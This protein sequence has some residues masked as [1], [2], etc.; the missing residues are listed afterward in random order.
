MTILGKSAQE[1]NPLIE[2]GADK[3]EELGKQAHDAGYVVSDEML[4]ALLILSYFSLL[5]SST[6]TGSH[7]SVEPS[8]PGTSIAKC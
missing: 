6:S 2:A 1:L 3:M 5:Y 7:H 8:T 4:N